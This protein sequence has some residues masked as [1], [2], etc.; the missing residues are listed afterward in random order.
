LKEACAHIS[1]HLDHT[2]SAHAEDEQKIATQ[3]RN[4]DGRLMTV[5]RINDLMK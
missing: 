1:N 4:D 2:R 3:M 5:S